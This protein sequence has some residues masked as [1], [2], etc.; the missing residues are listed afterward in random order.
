MHVESPLF[1][2]DKLKCVSSPHLSP[3]RNLQLIIPT[4]E[5]IRNYTD[6]DQIPLTIRISPFVGGEI[7]GLEATI[8]GSFLNLT[9]EQQVELYRIVETQKAVAKARVNVTI[10]AIN[11]EQHEQIDR[12][13]ASFKLSY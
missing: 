4:E 1:I 7:H 8:G 13:L 2:L 6:L 11:G 10:S 12:I 3:D 5:D 9:R